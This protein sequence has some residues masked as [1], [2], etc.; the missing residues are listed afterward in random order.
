M[1]AEAIVF[2][3]IVFVAGVKVARTMASI[4]NKSYSE[5]FYV[6]KLEIVASVIGDCEIETVAIL[7]NAEA[8][9]FSLQFY[10][11]QHL[12]IEMDALTTKVDFSKTRLCLYD[13]A[14]IL[15]FQTGYN[16]EK[17]VFYA[18]YLLPRPVSEGT[19]TNIWFFN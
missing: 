1:L 15:P 8:A 3:A 13:S 5:C 17:S 6:A 4:I 12:F 2:A 14:V 10:G 11:F 18:R 19:R 9:K 16:K 7:K